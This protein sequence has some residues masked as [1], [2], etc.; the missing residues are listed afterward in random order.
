M[1]LYFLNETEANTYGLT[2]Y[3]KVQYCVLSD[4]ILSDY[5]AVLVLMIFF[6]ISNVIIHVTKI[7]A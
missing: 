5:L 2:P 7:S 1:L 3:Y 6:L 4:L